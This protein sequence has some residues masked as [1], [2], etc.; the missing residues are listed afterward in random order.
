VQTYQGK[1]Y[2]LWFGLILASDAFIIPV[3]INRKDYN[4]RVRRSHLLILD[5]AVDLVLGCIFPVLAF[6]PLLYKFFMVQ[7]VIGNPEWIRKSLTLAHFN[8][9]TSM[10]DMVSTI[11]PLIFSHLLLDDLGIELRFISYKNV[12]KRTSVVKSRFLK[13]CNFMCA[14]WGALSVDS[15]YSCSYCFAMRSTGVTKYMCSSSV[16][17]VRTEWTMLLCKCW[18]IL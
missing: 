1:W 2:T 8:V 15:L 16:P 18:T 6:P 7:T 4:S 3:L 12:A 5:V 17:M 14:L 10:V 13:I 11:A 9:V